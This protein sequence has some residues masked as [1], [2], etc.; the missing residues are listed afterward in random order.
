DHACPN[1]Y[2]AGRVRAE[3]RAV[4]SCDRKTAE[5][6]LPAVR[7]DQGFAKRV[8]AMPPKATAHNEDR[9]TGGNF[10]TPRKT[11]R[12]NLAPI[13]LRCLGGALFPVGPLA[14]G[15]RAYHRVEL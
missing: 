4:L 8:H 6:G 2:V 11:V 14:V 3:Q 10:A 13:Y 9:A 5:A 12:E 7:A 1:G 15:N